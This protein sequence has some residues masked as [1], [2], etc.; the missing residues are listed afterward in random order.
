[1]ELIIFDDTPSPYP[2]EINDERVRYVHDNSKHYMLWE[3]RNRLNELAQGEII[4]CMDDDDFSMHNRIEKSIEILTKRKNVLICGSSSLYIYDT[5]VQQL[6]L[7]KP[8]RNKIIL[9]GT[10]AYKKS[11]LDRYKYQETKNN[12]LEEI[13]FTKN[14]TVP[15]IKIDYKD[16]IVCL[17][18]HENTVD[19]N[20]FCISKTISKDIILNFNLKTMYNVLPIIYWINLDKS[21]DR[22]KNMMKQFENFRYNERIEGVEEPYIKYN[23]KRFGKSQM[24]CLCSHLNAMKTSLDDIHRDYAIIC[25][26]DVYLKD[27]KAFHE[28]I[29]YYLQSTP[30]SWDILQL[31]SIKQSRNMKMDSSSLLRWEKWSKRNFSTLIYIIKKSYARQ[32][33]TFVEKINERSIGLLAD[34]FIYS[35]G[36]A[37]SIVC[38]YFEDELEFES[39]IDTSHRVFHENNK[40]KIKSALDSM[41]LKYPFRKN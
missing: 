20:Q 2:F 18:H 24:G 39:L 40:Q 7:F 12:N 1:M 27:I 14:F 5:F 8:F 41:D 25:E 9:N 10:F 11:M 26:D 31:Y 22:Y 17:N 30:K 13:S 16:T 34:E 33:L 29:Y 36:I 21:T 19:K 38:P 4:V 15:M 23:T 37:Y 35:K 3:K 28:I 6:Y 32:L